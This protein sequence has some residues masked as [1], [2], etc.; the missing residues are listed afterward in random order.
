MNILL[1]DDD[2]TDAKNLERML[3]EGNGAGPFFVRSVCDLQEA[4]EVW[5]DYDAVLLDLV[6]PPSTPDDVFS[7]ARMIRSDKP[8]VILSGLEDTQYIER[9]GECGF[10]FLQK[11]SITKNP[12]VVELYR[13]R[14]ALKAKQ[15][16]GRAA[17]V[18]TEERAK[19]FAGG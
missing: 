17:D 16:L 1:V 14:G 9:A 6:I 3:C 2:Q 13:A 15:R 19:L 5:R 4:R 11:G 8:V 10:G 7:F 18:L 12:L